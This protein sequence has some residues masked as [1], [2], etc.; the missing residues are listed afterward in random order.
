MRGYADGHAE[1]YRI[2]VAEA[3]AQQRRHE[4]AA[5]ERETQRD[6]EVAAAVAMLRAAAQAFEERTRAVTALSRQQVDAAAI[7]LAEVILVGELRQGADSTLA[8]IR[9]A[10]D[11][12]ADE[13][14]R[15][16]RLNADDVAQLRSLGALDAQGTLGALDAVGALGTAVQGALGALDALGALRGVA[17]VADPS[18]DRGDAVVVLDDGFIDARIAAA[19]DRARAVVAESTDDD[20]TADAASELPADAASAVPAHV[21]SEMPADTESAAPAEDSASEPRSTP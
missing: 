20:A 3:T 8:A 6:G 13:S 4:A 7:E 9:R 17:V 21:A 2:A 15:A 1:G 18:L 10:Q 11:A 5:A 12:A 19:L 14:A 16:V